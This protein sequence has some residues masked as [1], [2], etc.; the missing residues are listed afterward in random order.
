M[1]ENQK[2]TILSISYVFRIDPVTNESRD[3]TADEYKQLIDNGIN[4]KNTTA[5]EVFDKC[6]WCPAMKIH[7]YKEGKETF[8]TNEYLNWTL[9]YET[10]N[11]P[12]KYT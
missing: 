6:G 7:Y 4:P 5:E 1:T 12:R 8:V 10:G 9:P 2:S 3:L 11:L